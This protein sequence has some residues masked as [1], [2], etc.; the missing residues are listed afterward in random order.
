L[1]LVIRR[2][3]RGIAVSAKGKNVEWGKIRMSKQRFLSAFRRSVKSAE[4]IAKDGQAASELLEKAFQKASRNR[5]IL[6]DA[7]EDFFAL[8]RM[9]KASFQGSYTGVPWKSIVSAVGAIL[10]FVN[11]LDVIPDFFAGAGFFDDLSVFGFVLAMIR[12]DL[13]AFRLWEKGGAP[14]KSPADLPQNE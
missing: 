8:L 1:Q 2:S 6:G 5:K 7:Q 9:L 11:P 10:Y 13:D 3:A 4:S 12:V 14:E